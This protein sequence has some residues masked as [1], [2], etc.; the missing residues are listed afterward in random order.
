M[1][2]EKF[3]NWVRFEGDLKTVDPGLLI[4]VKELLYVN[5]TDT[6]DG[7]GVDINGQELEWNV[8]QMDEKYIKM[9]W[10]LVVK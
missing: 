3:G 2:G 8:E 4:E 5:A 10:G 9:S 1:V 6:L 7:V